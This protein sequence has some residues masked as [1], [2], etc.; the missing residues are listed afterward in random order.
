[1]AA[2]RNRKPESCCR[3]RRSARTASSVPAPGR[4]S[5][6]ARIGNPH[7]VNSPAGAASPGWMRPSD[8]LDRSPALGNQGGA[9]QHSRARRRQLALDAV[10]AR[11]WRSDCVA[12]KQTRCE[13]GF[14][15]VGP[16]RE[17]RFSR[18]P[19]FDFSGLHRGSLRSLLL[20]AKSRDSA[21]HSCRLAQRHL[22][23][24][25]ECT[26]DRTAR[27]K[28]VQARDRGLPNCKVQGYDETII[29]RAHMQSPT[30]ARSVWCDPGRRRCDRG[31]TIR[32][33]DRLPQSRP[34]ILV[35]VIGDGTQL[36]MPGW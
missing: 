17:Q 15:T 31:R 26:C 36:L 35:R 21:D 29:M 12:S 1:M 28:L 23:V 33:R 10:T 13:E 32:R 2:W 9:T 5:P 19:P 16:V 8:G 27:R 7:R 18:L 11:P 3:A 6:H 25:A 30:R 34:N 4:G 24:E 20:R 22:P 14:R